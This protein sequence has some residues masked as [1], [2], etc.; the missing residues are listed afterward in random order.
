MI[1]V[2]GLI[3]VSFFNFIKSF[4]IFKA[5][6]LKVIKSLLL[7]TPKILTLK[8][9][10]LK[11]CL[12]PL[13]LISKNLLITVLLTLTPVYYITSFTVHAA[14]IIIK[15]LRL[16]SIITREKVTNTVIIIKHIK[17]EKMKVI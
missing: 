13:L 15:A 8:N 1:K 10:I 2:S 4:E 3:K 14:I 9:L 12:L 16:K 6:F 11:D 7:L 17:R 5:L